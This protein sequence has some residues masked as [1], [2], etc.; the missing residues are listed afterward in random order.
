MACIALAFPRDQQRYWLLVN[1]MMKVSHMW[2]CIVS[3]DTECR[4]WRP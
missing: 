2:Y 1:G 4:C 3:V